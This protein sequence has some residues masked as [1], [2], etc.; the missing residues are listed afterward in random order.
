LGFAPYGAAATKPPL[1]ARRPPSRSS[2]A[3]VSFLFAIFAGF[4]LKISGSRR[5]K[6][7]TKDNVLVPVQG[8]AAT[9]LQPVTSVIR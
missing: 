8:K 1:P 2:A 3:T 6:I 4:A 9:G 7:L 5:R